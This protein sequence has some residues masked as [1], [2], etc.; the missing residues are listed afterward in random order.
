MIQVR[1]VPERLHRELLRRARSR[2]QSLTAYIESLL[3]REVSLPAA[4]EVW[5][6]IDSRSPALRPG[7][8]ARLVRA[9]RR[10]RDAVLGRRAKR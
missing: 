1:N 4:E 10:E 2:G 6:R 8:A 5:K 3:E 7:E 9:V